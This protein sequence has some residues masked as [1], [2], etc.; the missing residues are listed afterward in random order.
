MFFLLSR[1]IGKLPICVNLCPA[2]LYFI[3]KKCPPPAKKAVCTGPPPGHTACALCSILHV[4]PQKAGH[5]L[6]QLA[7]HLTGLPLLLPGQQ[8]YAA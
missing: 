5:R 7:L 2:L 4:P 3:A 1:K 8:H 6:D